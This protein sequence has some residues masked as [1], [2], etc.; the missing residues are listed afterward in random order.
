MR[1]LLFFF[2]SAIPKTNKQTNFGFI[3]VII[4]LLL[5][6]AHFLLSFPLLLFFFPLFLGCNIDSNRVFRGL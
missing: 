1:V 5:L 3:I 2:T 4:Y 6:T